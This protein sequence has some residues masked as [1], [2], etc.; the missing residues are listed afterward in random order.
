MSSS[1]ITNLTEEDGSCSI[2]HRKQ[3][4]KRIAEKRRCPARLFGVVS[5]Q[6][7]RVHT[8]CPKKA[9][10]QRSTKHG[11]THRCQLSL[12][13]GSY[14]VAGGCCVDKSSRK[15][16]WRIDRQL[17]PCPTTSEV[18]KLNSCWAAPD[19]VS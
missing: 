13:N 14:T 12:A 7:D 18:K 9:I 4:T 11:E 3:S 8:D 17:S 16:A 15:E 5:L 6:W 2:A 19:S 10:E 1:P